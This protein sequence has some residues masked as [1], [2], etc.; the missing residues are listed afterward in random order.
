[1][2]DKLEALRTSALE[3]LESA[4]STDEI[5]ALRTLYLGRKGRLTEVLRNEWGF[6][7]LVVSDW[8]ATNDRVAGV[9]AGM[10]LEMPGPSD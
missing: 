5:T 7:G 10:D 4:S 6:G 2:R 8:G 9:R 3:A 1:M